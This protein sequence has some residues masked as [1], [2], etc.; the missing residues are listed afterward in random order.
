MLNVASQGSYVRHGQYSRLV[1][2]PLDR[3][4]IVLGP[5][6]LVVVIVARHVKRHQVSE[7]EVRKRSGA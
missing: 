4:V 7:L 5:H 6:G 2:L 3:E 1:E